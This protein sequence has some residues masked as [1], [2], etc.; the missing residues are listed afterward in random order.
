MSTYEIAQSDSLK[1]YRDGLRKIIEYA[2][3]ITDFGIGEMDEQELREKY[4]ASIRAK[5]S[6]GKRLSSKEMQYLRKYNPILYA[7]VVRI[8]AKRRTVEEQ[9]KHADS[10]KQV[11]EI[12]FEAVSSI[13]K[14]DPVRE[15]MMAAVLEAVKEFKKTASYKKLP[16]TEETDKHKSD[17]KKNDKEEELSITYEFGAG[18]Y[19]LAY[20]GNQPNQEQMLRWE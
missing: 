19:Q 2:E 6:A 3:M 5:L 20:V 9:L 1:E 18:S 11:E 7:Q 15:Y 8:E 4:D 12:Q 16:E 17:K 14:K 10:K 13:S